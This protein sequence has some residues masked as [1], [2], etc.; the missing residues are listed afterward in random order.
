MEFTYVHVQS[1]LM[2]ICVRQNMHFF[3]ASHFKPL[4]QSKFCG[5]LIDNRADAPIFV[6]ED[7]DRE[8]KLNLKHSLKFFFG[9]LCTVEYV[10]KI[11]LC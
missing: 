11:T 1:D 3:Y 5:G 9:V 8:T 7:N 6:L 4:H 10:Y 2:G